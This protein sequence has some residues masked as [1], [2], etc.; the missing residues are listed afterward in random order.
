MHRLV[1]LGVALLIATGCCPIPVPK[2]YVA[3]PGV[4]FEVTGAPAEGAEVMLV[5][6]ER[7]YI[8]PPATLVLRERTDADGRVAFDEARETRTVMPLMMHGVPQYVFSWCVSAPGRAAVAGRLDGEVV[9]VVL[10]AGDGRCEEQYG[11]AVV[12]P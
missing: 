6:N 10:E 5:R 4:T 11:S 1:A 8:E 7:P 9:P 12:A 3:V 2:E